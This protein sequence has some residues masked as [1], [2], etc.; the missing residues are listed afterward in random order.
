M[1]AKYRIAVIGNKPHRGYLFVPIEEMPFTYTNHVVR[2]ASR[3]RQ[4][5]TIPEILQ[6]HRAGL[7]T[8]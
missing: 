1:H 6:K 5:R 2:A 3:K 8:L 7:D 4:M